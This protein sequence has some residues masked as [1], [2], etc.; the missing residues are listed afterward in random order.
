MY[1]YKERER[2]R[3]NRGQEEIFSNAKKKRL[4]DITVFNGFE[5]EKMIS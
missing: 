3:Q 5:N 1:I 4:C 2:G